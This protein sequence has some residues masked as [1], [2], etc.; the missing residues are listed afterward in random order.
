MPLTFPQYLTVRTLLNETQ[1]DL[2][3]AKS[4]RKWWTFDLVMTASVCIFGF[5]F[6]S[7]LVIYSSWGFLLS[8]NLSFRRHQKLVASAESKLEYL[9]Q[10]RKEYLNG[11]IN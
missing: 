3:D 4:L 1:A 5:L 9:N 11:P 2:D 7:L 8:W 10:I 6:E